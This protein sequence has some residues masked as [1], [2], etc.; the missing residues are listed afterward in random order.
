M[1]REWRDDLWRLI[2]ETPN[3]DWMLLTKRP[4]NIRKMLPVDW[5]QGFPNVWLG[6]TT[7]NQHYYDQRFPHLLRVPAVVRFISY[8]PA[9][10]P[11]SLGERAPDWVIAGGESGV[12]RYRKPNPTWLRN[13]RDQC[14]ELGIA[15]FFKQW[16]GLHPKD[17][18]RLLDGREHNDFPHPKGGV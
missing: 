6:T 10:G 5:R 2:S 7:E 18:G 4:Q 12:A 11:L 13:L 3:L 14:R 9:L 16:G 15:F 8:E 1:P 17:G